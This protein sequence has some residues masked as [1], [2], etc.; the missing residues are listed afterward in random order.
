[1]VLKTAGVSIFLACRDHPGIIPIINRDCIKSKKIL[2]TL[3]D[4]NG[5]Q[6]HST[7]KKVIIR[8]RQGFSV[9]IDGIFG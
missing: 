3:F 1:M 5:I 6:F 8:V 7:F 4:V 2:D 9:L